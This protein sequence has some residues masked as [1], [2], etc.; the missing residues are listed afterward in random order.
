MTKI[1][2]IF[3]HKLHNFK[4]FFQKFDRY[5][6]FHNLGSYGSFGNQ[7][8]QIF[9]TIEIANRLHKESKFGDW[10]YRKY[11]SFP[12]EIWKRPNE[13]SA[14]SPDFALHLGKQSIYLQDISLLPAD[15]SW[16]KKCLTPSK[17][18]NGRLEELSDRYSINERHA[19]HIRRGDYLMN[20]D[21]HTVPSFE[22]YRSG[23]QSN[24]LIFSDDIDW[25]YSKFPGTEIVRESEI[26]SWMLMSRCESFLISASSYS[27]WAAYLSGSKEVVYPEP[28]SPQSIEE[29]NT[30]LLIPN[31]FTPKPLM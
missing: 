18:L 9:A 16:M 7:L 15:K 24:S 3:T 14:N 17:Y 5:I 13:W 23:L 8:W 1:Q 29:W 21:Y 26:L 30:N 25:C 11:F 19:V 6:A 4:F 2:K 31:Y 22:W 28:W 12:D 20:S 27:W 10:T